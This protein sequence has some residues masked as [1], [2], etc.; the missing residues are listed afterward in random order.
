MERANRR[1]E[2]ILP[3][4]ETADTIGDMENRS[5]QPPV[6]P[7]SRRRW[8][9][10]S[11]RT[12]V[13]AVTLF[14]IW[15]GVTAN[16][17]NRQRRA[18]ETIKSHGG[19]V[20][21]DYEADEHGGIAAHAAPPPG[22]DWLRNLIGLDYFAT[23]VM[24]GVDSQNGSVDDSVAAL[25]DLPDLRSLTL[26]GAGVTDS[27]MARV[28][29]LTKLHVLQVQKSAITE[30]G[31]KPLEQLNHLWLL[32]LSDL[33]VTD[34]ALEHLEGYTRLKFLWLDGSKRLTDA[35][36]QHLQNLVELKSLSVK[37]TAITAQGVNG[38]TRVLPKLR[39]AVPEV[40]R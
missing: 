26:R 30:A 15:L 29:S 8:L 24:V 32:E 17:A 40:G 6:V 19:Y 20:R 23:V 9:R 22:P 33:H 13:L 35:G 31:W 16:R 37:G 27:I 38:L 28:G 1:A 11:L 34:S 7:K 5:S 25:T 21:Y 2:L 12:M 14:C 10:F 3:S 39:V 4:G 18:V 36:L